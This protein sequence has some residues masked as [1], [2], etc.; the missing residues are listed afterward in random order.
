MIDTCGSCFQTRTH[1][2]PEGLGQ[3]RNEEEERATCEN[4]ELRE[5]RLRPGNR[6]TNHIANGVSLAIQTRGDEGEGLVNTGDISD[7]MQ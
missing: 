2:E 5:G 7:D 4:K 3:S 1:D 6:A